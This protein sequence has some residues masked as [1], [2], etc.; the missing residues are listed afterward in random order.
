VSYNDCCDCAILYA[1]R[2]PFLGVFMCQV[3]WGFFLVLL[4]ISIIVN[5]VFGI[6]V[7]VF[8]LFFAGFL[9]YL[10]VRV[11]MPS[12]QLSWHWSCYKCNNES[13]E[14]Q[15]S[16]CDRDLYEVRFSESAVDLRLLNGLTE[17]KTI[18]IV[19]RFAHAKVILPTNVPVRVK[20]DVS[21]GAVNLPGK[22]S[23]SEYVNL[24]G[25]SEPVL[26]VL[27]ESSFSSVDVEE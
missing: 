12:S 9:I 14:F 21:F 5:V 17:P 10:G 27:I 2:Q 18:R 7:P 24:Y 15:E 1:V 4:G 8:K 13:C 22:S 23:H 19:V 16:S 26:T 3:C 25:A 6:N 11:L 20:A